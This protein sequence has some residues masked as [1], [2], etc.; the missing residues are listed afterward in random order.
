MK[1]C[2]NCKGSGLRQSV[3]GKDHV[4]TTLPCHL[5]KGKGELDLDI[6]LLCKSALKKLE[7]KEDEGEVNINDSKRAKKRNKKF[8]R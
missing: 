7:S 1:Y 3:V 4:L 6:V 2:P 5:C 8:A